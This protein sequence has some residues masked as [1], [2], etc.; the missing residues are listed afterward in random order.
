MINVTAASAADRQAVADMLPVLRARFPT[1][2][3]LWADD[4]Y[5]GVLITLALAV[6]PAPGRHCDQTQRRRRRLRGA[7]TPLG[8]STIFRLAASLAPSG[9]RLRAAP[10][11]QRGDDHVVDDPAHDPPPRSPGANADRPEDSLTSRPLATSRF[12]CDRTP[13]VFERTGAT[14]SAD[15]ISLQLQ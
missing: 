8:G 7:T 10:G 14:P 15:T 13:S 1:I 6:L 9:P 12:V 5:T 11:L 2:T 4:G 3:R